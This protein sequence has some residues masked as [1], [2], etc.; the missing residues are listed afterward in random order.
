[1][2]SIAVP[3]PA[4]IVTIIQPRTYGVLYLRR[5]ASDC[6]HLVL[7]TA[8]VPK[9]QLWSTIHTPETQSLLGISRRSTP[10][11]RVHQSCGARSHAATPTTYRLRALPLRVRSGEKK[12]LLLFCNVPIDGLAC[13]N[14]DRNGGDAQPGADNCV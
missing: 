7:M 9:P 2:S 10:S 14:K 5:T 6:D 1:M 4:V 8:A 13:P 3:I 12:D 11:T